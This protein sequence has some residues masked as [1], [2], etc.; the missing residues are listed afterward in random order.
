MEL[1]QFVEYLSGK[2]LTEQQKEWLEL[3]KSKSPTGRTRVC[4]VGDR[5]NPAFAIGNLIHE[6][7]NRLEDRV[8]AHVM[9]NTEKVEILAQASFLGTSY[10][11]VWFDEFEQIHARGIPFEDV[12]LMGHRRQAKPAVLGRLDSVRLVPHPQLCVTEH[13]ADH[14][15]RKRE[16]K[17]PRGRWGK[18]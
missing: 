7:F 8:T 1:D 2:P 5:F 13:P 4:V 14:L 18:L 10:T 11:E 15:T 6:D 12:L 9:A 17:G 16:P 3:A